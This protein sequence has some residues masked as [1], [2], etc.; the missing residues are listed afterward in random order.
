MIKL[1]CLVL[2]P[3]LSYP[4]RNG[5][6]ILIDRRWAEFSH[7]VGYVDIL[8]CDALVRYQHGVRISEQAYLNQPRSKLW[9]SF[10]TIVGWSHYL[11]EKFITQRFVS[12]ARGLLVNPEYGMVVYSYISTASLATFGKSV[13]R[14]CCIETHNDEIKWF[15][16]MRNSTRNPLVK[17]TAW[18]SEHWLLGFMR[19]HETDFLYLHVTKADQ[20]GYA[21]YFPN[22]SCYVAP[23]GCDI[24]VA[25]HGHAD[26][27]P[28]RPIRL[29]FVGSLGV[30]MNFDA[31]KYFSENFYSVIS[32]GLVGQL[33]LRIVGSN[34]SSQVVK[35]CALMGWGL[36]AD[37]SEEEL[38]AAYDWADFS[39][40]P[41]AYA[42]G[43]KLKLLKSLSQA[44]PFLAT[45]VVCGQMDEIEQTCLVSDQPLE[46]LQHIVKFRERGISQ[47][48]RTRLVL[49]AQSYS[50]SQI[51][52]D[53]YR[54][55]SSCK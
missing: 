25:L 2:A 14:L 24:D 38:S 54:Y 37:V 41:F 21:R 30:K 55:L 39:I 47:E 22:H 28:A 12:M 20:L 7:H 13:D 26:I 5:A 32:Q 45:E 11:L 35:L 16:D 1:A 19:Q 10:R 52:S 31:I 8:G 51:A 46:W 44:V 29:L 43:G 9:S 50:W 18:L 6:D 48:Q 17:M 42:T 36:K 34:P 3:H 27:E 33:E 15:A 53:L 23:V 49:C 40:L 4:T